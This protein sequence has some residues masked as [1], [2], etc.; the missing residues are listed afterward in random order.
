MNYFFSQLWHQLV[1]LFCY[2][3][4]FIENYFAKVV[5]RCFDEQMQGQRAD[6]Y[7]RELFHVVLLKAKRNKWL[8]NISCLF[9]VSLPLTHH[10]LNKL[11][12]LGV[13]DFADVVEKNWKLC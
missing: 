12:I 11:E 1:N 2:N 4:F 8:K 13:T 9:V 7:S 6:N 3:G 5:K 10:Y